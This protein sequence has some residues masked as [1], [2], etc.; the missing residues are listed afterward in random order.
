MSNLKQQRYEELRRITDAEDW[1][2]DDELYSEQCQLFYE[3]ND[4]ARLAMFWALI[5]RVTRG[6]MPCQHEDVNIQQR[7]TRRVQG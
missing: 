3:L 1:Q 6:E 4:R 5:H 2:Y 7:S